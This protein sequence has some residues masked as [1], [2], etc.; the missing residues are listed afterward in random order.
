[1]DANDDDEWTRRWIHA[2]SLLS[3]SI[4]HVTTDTPYEPGLAIY[5]IAAEFLHRLPL[6]ILTF[7]L[8]PSNAGNDEVT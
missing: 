6:T 4:W 3:I 7:P 8:T 5:A 1:M 2:L